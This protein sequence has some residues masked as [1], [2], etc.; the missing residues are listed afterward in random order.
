[1]KNF[2]N[3]FKQAISKG[4]DLANSAMEKGSEL[5]STAKDIATKQATQSTSDAMDARRT[6]A[7]DLLD[8]ATT[9]AGEISQSNNL[10]GF[11]FEEEQARTFNEAAAKQGSSLRAVVDPPGGE[12]ARGAPDIRIVDSETG[13][14]VKSYQAKMGQEKYID[15]QLG[16]DKYYDGRTDAFV[17]DAENSLNQTL[18]DGEALSEAVDNI[19]WDDPQSIDDFLENFDPRGGLLEADAVISYDD[20]ES[21]VFLNEE[22]EAIAEDPAAYAQDLQDSAN[23]EEISSGAVG[24]AAIAAIF[25]AIH[26]SIKILA[27]VYKGEDV[28]KEVV[29]GAL[30]NVMGAAASGA[31]RGGLIK[32]VKIILEKQMEDSGSLPLVIISVA[33]IVY[34]TLLQY[35]QGEITLEECIKE[36]GSK[37]LSRAMIVTM[38]IL[39][40]PLGIALM[41]ISILTAIWTEF[42]VANQIKSTYPEAE[43][44]FELAREADRKKKNLIES[45]KEKLEQT[46]DVSGKVIE[47]A[48]QKAG[49]TGG[50]IKDYCNRTVSTT[51]DKL[52]N[53]SLKRKPS[54]E[55]A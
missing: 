24:G 8:T 2:A 45:G 33:P 9:K 25:Q 22:M 42:D 32:V 53:M 29:V 12:D 39:F 50:N 54:E 38:G 21:E 31:L 17:V 40:P 11:M 27:K 47:S 14:T 51:K 37:A 13:D 55:T 52:G 23:V 28:P 7:D 30:K 6:G 5:A 35:L 4:A 26:G 49:E 36:V 43:R 34:K 41:G 18:K 20:I 3:G 10:K 19:D 15:K 48:K 1:M 16:E 46:K 44:I